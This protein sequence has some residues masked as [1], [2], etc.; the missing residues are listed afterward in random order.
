M[1]L[2]PNRTTGPMALCYPIFAPKVDNF[3]FLD[4][5]NEEP[6]FFFFIFFFRTPPPSDH[7]LPGLRSSSEFFLIFRPIFHLEDLSEDRDRPSTLESIRAALPRFCRAPLAPSSLASP[8]CAAP[9][10]FPGFRLDSSSD[11]PPTLVRYSEGLTSDRF[12]CSNLCLN[13]EIDPLSL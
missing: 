5:R 4:R 10:R 12:S 11:T 9:L 7:P 3:H 6:L 2:W 1:V 13:I 8:R